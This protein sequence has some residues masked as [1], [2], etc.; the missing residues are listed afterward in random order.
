MGFDFWVWDFRFRVRDLGF[1]IQGFGFWVY[2]PRFR[3][4]GLGLSLAGRRCHPAASR[5]ALWRP[6]PGLN[7]KTSL[8]PKP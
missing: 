5:E 4:L 1:R 8:D 3:I 7:P 2:S 6:P